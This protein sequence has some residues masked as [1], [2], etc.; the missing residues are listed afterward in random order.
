MQCPYFSINSFL[1]LLACLLFYQ[2]ADN[3]SADCRYGSPKAIFSDALPSIVRHE[4]KADGQQAQERVQFDNG[5]ALELL[6]S[7]CN[8]IQQEFRFVQAL[9]EESLPRDS[10]W[11]E[12]AANLLKYLSNLSEEHVS[13]GQWAQLIDTQ[14]ENLKLGQKME[15]QPQIFVRVDRI[16]MAQENLIVIELSQESP[17]G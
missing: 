16:K 2:C 4:F 9:Q 8:S 3:S 17:E 11:L 6:Q 14:K 7:G 1:L 12:Q 13:F 15:V 10:Y 5:L